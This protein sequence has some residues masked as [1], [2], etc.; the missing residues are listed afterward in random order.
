LIN[1]ISVIGGGLMG[2]GI[3]QVVAQA[4][5]EVTLVDVDSAALDR[6]LTRI[7][8]GYARLHAKGVLSDTDAA[9]ALTRIRPTTSLDEAAERADHVIETVIEDIEV[10]KA[11]LRTLGEL[12]RDDV[13]FATNTSQFSISAL[14]AAS[15]RPDR[16]IGSHWFNPAPVMRLIEIV[17]G[18]ETS[19]ETLAVALELA[20]RY[21]KETVVCLKDAPGFITSRLIA[22]LMIEAARIVDEGI[23]S[24]EDVNK[25]CVL[26]FNHAQGP[27]DT[28]DLSGLDTIER[29]GTALAAQYGERF[30]PPNALRSLVNAGHYGRKTGRGFSDYDAP[31]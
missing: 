9:A 13:V 15:G 18:V 1:Q 7:A 2:S 19:D 29:I 30:L 8:A 27:L 17:R 31:A 10:K 11:V 23:A 12:C 14:A 22:L 21:G 4:G 5:F 26:A 6:A 28:A 20:E 25:A 16:V 24:V 3:S